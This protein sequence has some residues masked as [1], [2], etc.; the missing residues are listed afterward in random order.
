MIGRGDNWGPFHAAIS[1]AERVARLRGLRAIVGLY[2]GRMHPL[3]KAL[4]LAET[5]DMVDLEGALLELDR[6]PALQR[7]R[8][9]SS[10]AA[11]A[12]YKAQRD[13]GGATPAQLEG[14]G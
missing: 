11:H 9:L 1:H 14:A 10:Y 5:G 3:V 4:W 8:V 13:D 6:L 7:R 2:C 12:S